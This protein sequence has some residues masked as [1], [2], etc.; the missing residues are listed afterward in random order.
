MT[1]RKY[2]LILASVYL[3]AFWLLRLFFIVYNGAN[4]GV[5]FGSVLE[6]YVNGLPSDIITVAWILLLPWA[7]ATVTLLKPA[8]LYRRYVYPWLL[9]TNILVCLATF[10]DTFLYEHWFFKLHAYV[11]TYLVSPDALGDS[12][13]LWESIRNFGTPVVVMVLMSWLTWRYTP[14]SFACTPYHKS[15]WSSEE[16]D[17]LVAGVI[18]ILLMSVSL[19]RDFDIGRAYR[20]DNLF[21][22]HAAV[23]PLLNFSLTGT[24]LMHPY[25][26][27]YGYFDADEAGRRFEGLY[28]SDTEDIA[29]TLL[30]ADRPNVLFIQVESMGARFIEALGGIP[31]VTPELNRWMKNGICFDNVYAN[32]FR[33][34]RATVCAASGWLAYPTVGVSLKPE[35]VAGLPSVARSMASAGYSTEWI[36]GASLNDMAID[37]YLETTGYQKQTSSGD[38]PIA[39][40]DRDIWGVNDSISMDYLYDRISAGMPEPWFITYQTISSHEPWTISYGPLKDKVLNSFAY[41]DHYLGKLLDRLSLTPQWDNL[42]I[43]IYADHSFLYKQS[44]EDPEY[45]HIPLLLTGGAVKESRVIHTVMNQSDIAATVLSQLQIPHTD[46][47]WSRNVLSANYIYPFAYSNYLAGAMFRDSTGASMVDLVANRVISKPADG[48]EERFDR[49]RTILQYSYQLLSPKR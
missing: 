25:D 43:V 8:M 18:I 48:D 34:D 16:T 42:L 47:P 49:I 26:R 46:F 45:F 5:T 32:S 13:S 6:S 30:R 4:F 41:T 31:G 27:Q 14:I 39:D 20:S 10:G 15:R 36:Y 12:L 22:N 44:M 24:A 28:P 40:E 29:D 7:L 38:I 21:M 3:L 23:N 9:L 33:T 35:M 2:L 11:L 1:R 37:K 17:S 19:R